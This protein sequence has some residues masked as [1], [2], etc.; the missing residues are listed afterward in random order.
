MGQIDGLA[1]HLNGILRGADNG[2]PDALCRLDYG[3]SAALLHLL[4]N[5]AGERSCNISIICGFSV[6]DVFRHPA[7]KGYESWPCRSLQRLGQF[8][9]MA[10]IIERCADNLVDDES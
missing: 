2:R 6:E 9:C 7:G 10:K 1:T 8:E 5:F 4:E 3:Y